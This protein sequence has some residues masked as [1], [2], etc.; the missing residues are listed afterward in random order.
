VADPHT[1]HL[2]FIIED[3]PESLAVDQTHHRVDLY[4]Y[5]S[6]MVAAMQVQEKEIAALRQELQLAQGKSACAP[7]RP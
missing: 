5:V 4:G 3:Q 1:K 2:G 7:G 6:M